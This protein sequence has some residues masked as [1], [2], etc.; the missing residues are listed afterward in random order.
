[1]R[2]VNSKK[3]FNCW[4]LVPQMNNKTN[5]NQ[6]PIEALELLPCY[7]LDLLAAKERA[8]VEKTLLE[9]PE[10]QSHL[11]TEHEMIKYLQE[12]KELFSLSAIEQRERKLATLLERD[13]F[14]LSNE[15]ETTDKLKP[16]I[17]DKSRGFFQNLLSG[18]MSQTQYLGFAA[19]S[20]LSIALLFAF[21]APLL[22]KKN[23]GTTSST[24]YPAAEKEENAQRNSGSLIVGLSVLPN[25]PRLTKLLIPYGASASNIPGKDSM[26]HINFSKQPDKPTLDKLLLKLSAEKELVWFIGEAY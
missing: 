5:N 11:K 4:N 10:L 22:D 3:Y 6:I 9:F 17:K 8:Y 1:M 25:D 19:I 15:T 13:E 12:E 20:T 18:Q 16:T 26:Y 24:F 2:E 14:N 23:T 21:V 7:A